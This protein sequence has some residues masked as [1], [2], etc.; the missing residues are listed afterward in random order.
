MAAQTQ[1]EGSGGEDWAK[2][3]SQCPSVSS[4][5]LVPFVKRGDVQVITVLQVPRGQEPHWSH[6]PVKPPPGME[7][8]TF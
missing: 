8:G 4:H 6:V 3:G 7:L 1:L 2:S 5:Y